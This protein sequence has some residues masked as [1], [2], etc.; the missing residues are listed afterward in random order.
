MDE[1]AVSPHWGENENQRRAKYYS[2]P[3]SGRARFKLASRSWTRVAAA[4]PAPLSA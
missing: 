1:A 2:L 4:M 3:E